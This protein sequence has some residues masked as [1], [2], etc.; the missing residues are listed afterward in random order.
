MKAKKKAIKKKV[1]KKKTIK[2]DRLIHVEH[3]NFAGAH[4]DASTVEAIKMIAEGLVE[5]AKALG[6]LA[7]VLKPSDC[8]KREAFIVVH[9]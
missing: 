2:E 4:Y 3:C 1:V 7:Q 6:N 9:K 8:Q 5:N